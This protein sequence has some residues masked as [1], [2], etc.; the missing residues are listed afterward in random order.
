LAGLAAVGAC[1]ACCAVPLLA[2]GVGGGLLSTIGAY[3]QSGSHLLFAGLA[4]ASVLG[5]LMVVRARTK[6]SA[7]DCEVSCSTTCGCGCGPSTSKPI[8]TSSDP[9]PNEPVVCTANLAD[10]QMMRA[11]L[12]SYRR[13][14]T[15]LRATERF[16]GGFSWVFAPAKGLE[17]ELRTLA[18]NEHRCC[19]FFKFDVRAEGDSVIWETR[20]DDRSASVIQEFADLPKRLAEAAPGEDIAALKRS[21]GSAGL[22]FT[23]DAPPSK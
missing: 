23:A 17:E 15:H 21:I 1:A 9:A 12:D 6:T 2:V 20:G 10:E 4:G 16:K 13:A 8:F 3:L 11:H 7:E 5:V 22:I 14:F 19:R 18:E